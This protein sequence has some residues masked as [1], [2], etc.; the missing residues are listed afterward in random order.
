VSRVLRGLLAA[1]GYF[2]ILPAGRSEPPATPGAEALGWLPAIGAVVG[3][4]AGLGGYGAAR[5]H[6]PWAFVVAWALAIGLTGALHVDGLLDACDGLFASASPQR[7]LEILKDVHHG[8]FAIAGMAIAGAFWL[9]ALAAIA[10]ARYPLAL[11][12]SGAAARFAAIA[13]AWSF[14]YA[15]GGSLNAAFVARPSLPAAAIDFAGV[16]LLAW[17]LNPW[18]LVL[19]PLAIAF[20]W[21]C[22]RWAS[23]RL[24][25]VLTGDAYGALIVVTEVALLLG[26]GTMLR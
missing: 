20:A 25:G 17:F 21:A 2:T 3:C 26:L 8:T 6:L 1:F 7:R 4:I 22:A 23:G 16:E 14:P 13:P 10:P 9:A 11:A 18:A 12:F 19:A 24:G 5:L 15:R